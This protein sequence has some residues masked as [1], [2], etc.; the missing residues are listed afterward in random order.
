MVDRTK[1]PVRWGIA[2]EFARWTTHSALRNPGAPIRKREEV[3]S[4][5]DTVNFDPLFDARTGAIDSHEFTDW[6]T[7][8]IS[9]L[10]KWEKR[11]TYG[12]SA[13]IIA[14]YLKTTCYM[15]GYGREGL[16]DVIHPPIDNELIRAV[17][18]EAWR[19]PMIPSLLS[20]FRTIRDMDMMTYCNTIEAF[21][22]IA[23]EMN[24]RLFEV[25]Q[26]WNLRSR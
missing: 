23:E 25:E 7:G 12:W 6:H 14:V 20:E 21:K 16:R 22:L 9:E 13:K 3:H 26:F 1:E 10:L 24:C 17:K 4:A 8:Q 19:G 18:R 5:L 2:H 15:A 11:L